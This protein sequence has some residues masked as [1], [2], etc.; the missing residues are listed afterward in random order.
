M[1]VR[2]APVRLTNE[3]LPDEIDSFRYSEAVVGDSD[4]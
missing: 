1:A 2:I 3:I 4:S